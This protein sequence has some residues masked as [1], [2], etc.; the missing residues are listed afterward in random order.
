MSET[1]SGLREEFFRWLTYLLLVPFFALATAFFGSLAMLASL[2][3]GSGRLQHTIAQHWA[4]WVL[5]ITLSPVQVIG[6]E[7]L[8]AV[9]VA[10]YAANHLSYLDTPVVF[11]HLPFQFRIL[12]RHDLFR[13][14]FIGWYLR[15][16]GQIPVDSTS[17]R[18]TI[19]SLN[20]GVRALK[21]GMPLM[22]FPEGG[23]TETGHLQ[24]FQNGAAF[25]ALRAGVPLVPM[26]LVG[27]YEMMPMHTYHVH[28]RP[29]YLV[30]GQPI[31][32]EKLAS[33]SL[34]AL[35]ARLHGAIANLYYQYSSLDAPQ[36]AA[37]RA[38][39]PEAAVSQHN[40]G[41]AKVF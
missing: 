35:T 40:S 9:P 25:M 14:P 28:P 38:D 11:R 22:I 33:H 18:S 30:V 13:I 39:G 12:A 26:A 41:P 36:S 5:R 8:H 1:S 31:P 2:F 23:R 37:S 6:A 32:T 19:A 20:G 4:G 24:D 21:A 17:L 27:T 15:R 16:S 7:N 34:D 3:D 10:V 29:L